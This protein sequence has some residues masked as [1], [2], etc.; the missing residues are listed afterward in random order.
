M[1][2]YQIQSVPLYMNAANFEC[3]FFKLGYEL[4]PTLTNFANLFSFLVFFNCYKTN[5][6]YE[7]WIEK[8]E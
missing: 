6:R 8:R 5:I 3:P 2:I 1:K 7:N 4:N